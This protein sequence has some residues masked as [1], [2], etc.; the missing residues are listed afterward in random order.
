MKLITSLSYRYTRL[1][2]LILG[3]LA[4]GCSEDYLDRKPDDKIDESQVFTRYNKTNQLVT[5]L[6]ANIK[7]ANR[8]L[9]FFNH[10]SSA[11]VTDEAEGSTAEGSL[12]NKFNS[13]DWSSIAM[14]DRSSTGQYWWDLYTKIRKANVILEGI[15]KYNTPDNPL[16]AGDL[17]K[18]IG[19][20]Y[21]M[22]AYLHYLTARMY[23]EI[24]YL[25]RT[26]GAKDPMEFKQESFHAIVAKIEQDCDS[27][28]ARVPATWGGSDFGRIDKGACLGLKAIVSW[29]A[30]TPL[31]NGGQLPNDTRQFKAEYA[32]NPARWV[33]AREA[34]KAVIDFK[35]DGQQRYSLYLGHDA[36]DFKDDAGVN[37]NNSK[38]YARLWDMYYSMD[39][40][41]KE[42]VFMVTK[43]KNQA[44]QGDIYPPSWGGSS[45]QMPVQ[46]QVDEYEYISKDGYGYPVYHANAKK[47][48]YDDENPFESVKR[49]PRFYRDIMYHGSTFKGKQINIAEGA[50]K[51]GASN[52]TTT[53]YFLRKFFKES[54]NRDKSFDISAPPIWRLP[55]FIYIYCEAVNES[56]GPN[57]EIYEMLNQVR[58]RSFMAPLPPAAMA[59]KALMN[60]YIQRERRVELFYENNRIWTF[61]LY[62]EPSSSGELAKE[63]AWQSAGATNDLRSQSYWPYPKAQRMINGMKPVEDPEG[64]IIIGAKK[65]KMKRFF[66]ENRVFVAPRHYLFPIMQDELQRTPGLIQNP[67]W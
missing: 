23:G 3:A 51:I 20:T 66:V 19:E 28:M 33:K 59:N 32:S 22:R 45:R 16:Q 44:W 2:I 31:W 48:G 21:F 53:G 6:Y 34:A 27:A 67:G 54:W 56:T 41:L 43:D 60:E 26:I 40:Y 7:G 25:N 63:Q 46:E 10:F 24:V 52:S 8:P 4:L 62:L 38:V 55:E 47:D 18:R 11:P 5:D 9:V 61:R 12:T 36:T 49:D 57:A 64:K 58:K 65:Y 50:D 17:E 15:K 37:N 13:G 42:S 35:A 14:P 30:A 1:T 39:A 29:M